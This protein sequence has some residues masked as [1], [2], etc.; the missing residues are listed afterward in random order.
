MT[1]NEVNHQK[2]LQ[3]ISD[4]KTRVAKLENEVMKTNV[5]ITIERGNILLTAAMMQLEEYQKLKR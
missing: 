2:I 5:G 3:E 4:V 1:S